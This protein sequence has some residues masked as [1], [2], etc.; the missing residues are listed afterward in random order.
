M[1]LGGR[2]G[3]PFGANEVKFG[4]WGGFLGRTIPQ[5]WGY[6]SAYLPEISRLLRILATQQIKLRGV[7]ICELSWLVRSAFGSNN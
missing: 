6:I 5:K 7:A 2:R 4:S 1:P 3:A